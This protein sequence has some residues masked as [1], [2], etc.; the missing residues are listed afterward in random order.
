MNQIDPYLLDNGNIVN[1][2]YGYGLKLYDELKHLLAW[3]EFKI[4]LNQ[5]KFYYIS[6]KDNKVM[7][8]IFDPADN[9]LNIVTKGTSEKFDDSEATPN[10]DSIEQYIALV[11]AQLEKPEEEFKP[12]QSRSQKRIEEF[13]NTGTASTGLGVGLQAP[14]TGNDPVLGGAQAVRA[15]KPKPKVIAFGPYEPPKTYTGTEFGGNK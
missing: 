6:A 3:D 12:G 9:S 1:D 8:L 14:P 7:T 13:A 11:T 5:G 2:Y 15:K 4:M 10:I